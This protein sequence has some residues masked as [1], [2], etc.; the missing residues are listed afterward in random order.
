MMV[1]KAK[2]DSRLR[3]DLMDAVCRIDTRR[4]YG[5][6]LFDLSSAVMV[7]HQ[8]DPA[9]SS[10][11][12]SMSRLECAGHFGSNEE[13]HEWPCDEVIALARVLGVDL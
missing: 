4:R 2:D 6:A 9:W 1:S 3:A 7:A 5:R 11:T 8:P 12:E 13:Q 10:T